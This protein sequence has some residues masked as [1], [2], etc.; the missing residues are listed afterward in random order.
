MNDLF[1]KRRQK[2]D[3][4]KKLREGNDRTEEIIECPKCGG[5]VVAKYSKTKTVFYCCDNYPECDF[6]SWDM[7]LAEKCPECGKN[8]FRKKGKKLAVCHDKSCGY[9]RELTDAESNTE[10]NV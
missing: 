10:E 1:L 7:P 3:S 5:K 9:E 8:L 4:L 2:L 6:S